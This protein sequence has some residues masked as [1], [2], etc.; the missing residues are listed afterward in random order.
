MKIGR[1]TEVLSGNLPQ[2][3]FLHH[4]HHKTRPG[5]EPGPA[6]WEVSD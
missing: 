4:K 3:H 6:R 2:F 1:E 5:L